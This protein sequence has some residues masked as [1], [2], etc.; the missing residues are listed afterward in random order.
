MP[1]PEPDESLHRVEVFEVGDPA[2]PV[3]LPPVSARGLRLTRA[4]A[5]RLNEVLPEGFSVEDAEGYLWFDDRG[6]AGEAIGG[7]MDAEGSDD[8]T[9]RQI[10]WSALDGIQQ[11]LHENQWIWGS[12]APP[13][14]GHWEPVVRVKGGR[15]RARFRLGPALREIPPEEW[16][17][18]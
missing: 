11:A 12:D 5:V 6:R 15:I 2:P 7:W 9:V 8:A 17:R 3:G 10:V 14:S 18:D 13:P 4:L 1:A 16:L